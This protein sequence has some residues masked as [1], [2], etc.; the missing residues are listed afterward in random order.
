M[1]APHPALQVALD[2]ADA[3]RRRAP[4]EVAGLA[5]G[6]ALLLVLVGL[7]SWWGQ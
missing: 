7:M 1:P 3:P 2:I 6:V 4:R 5:F